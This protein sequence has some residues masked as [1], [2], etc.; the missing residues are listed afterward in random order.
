MSR[1]FPLI[2]ADESVDHRIVLQ[3][4]HEQFTVYSITKETPGITDTEVIAISVEMNGFILTEDKDFGDELV[5]RKPQNIGS[6][7]LR[8]HDVPVDNKI[9]LVVDTLHNHASEL[10]G[11]FSVLTSKKLR[12]RKYNL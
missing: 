6:M 7:L 2:I 11:N 1:R 5:Y 12:I 9:K 8:M 3:L 10:R 4:I